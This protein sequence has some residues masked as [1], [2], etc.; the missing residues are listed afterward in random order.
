MSFNKLSAT[1]NA[2][3]GAKTDKPVGA[4]G[5]GP[6]GDKPAQTTQGGTKP[7]DRGQ[8]DARKDQAARKPM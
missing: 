1:N 8:D 3:E 6:S 5:A 2:S 4:K 7:A